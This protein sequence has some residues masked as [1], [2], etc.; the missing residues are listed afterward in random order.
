MKIFLKYFLAVIFFSTML[1][2]CD[3]YKNK[4]VLMNRINTLVQI[5]VTAKHA[6]DTF[7]GKRVVLLSK[8]GL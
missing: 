2:A 6:L 3:K 5:A 1:I 8:M 7:I 4:D